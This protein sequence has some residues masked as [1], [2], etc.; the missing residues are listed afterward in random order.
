M[1]PIETAY[2]WS[3]SYLAQ[4]D[5]STPALDARILLSYALDRSPESLFAHP[6]TLISR[7][8]WDRFRAL[9]ERRFRREPVSRILGYREFW[10]LEF[11]L[12][13]SALDPRPE[14]ETIVETALDLLPAPLSI[15]DLGT[16]SGCLLI[17]LVLEYRESFGIGV[18]KEPQAAET[19]ALNAIR[20]GVEDRCHWIVSD[21]GRGL[22]YS[23]DLIVCNPPYIRE[24]DLPELEPE[25][26]VYD[27]R[28]ALSGGLDGQERYRELI[29]LLP[30]LLKADGKVILEFGQGM[31]ADIA[32]L[33]ICH[34]LSPERIVPDLN[35]T[36]RCLVAAK[37]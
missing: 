3:R 23:F 2:R 32:A 19:A 28:L 4:A 9:L 5:V 30:E 13:A 21:W 7:E 14:S 20:H 6:E 31:S 18:D 17:S 10:G 25:V 11:D 33:C 1:I 36:Y 15:L 37:S 12:T 27:P 35:G 16:G 34:G 22:G 24:D 29:P 8:E 26:R